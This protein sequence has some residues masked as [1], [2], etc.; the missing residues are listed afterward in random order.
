MG[1]LLKLFVILTYQEMCFITTGMG[2]FC[3][4]KMYLV[5]NTVIKL[6]M[7]KRS[8][9]TTGY[10]MPCIKNSTMHILLRKVV[11]GPISLFQQHND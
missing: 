6:E 7:F 1:V 4:F 8:R 9:C 5:Y 11:V 3:E 2:Q 10:A